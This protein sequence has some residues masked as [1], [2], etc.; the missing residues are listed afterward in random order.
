MNK[1]SV[2]ANTDRWYGA[3]N[4]VTIS[5]QPEKVRTRPGEQTGR[6]GGTTAS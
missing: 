4:Q 1:G 5:T 6:G 2:P 3:S